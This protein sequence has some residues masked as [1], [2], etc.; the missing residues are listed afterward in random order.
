[1]TKK[2]SRP[3]RGRDRLLRHAATVF[4]TK[5]FHATGIDHLIKEAGVA[6][7][8]LYNNFPSKDDL[9]EAVLVAASGRVMQW[10]DRELGARPGGPGEKLL[11]LFDIFEGWYREPDFRG[12]LFARAAC[13]YPDRDHPAHMA[14]AQH[15]RHL[16]DWIE[17]LASDAGA[18]DAV[19]LAQQ[20][21]LLLQGA[22]T[23]AE[24]SGAFIAA[25]RARV[26]AER[27]IGAG[28]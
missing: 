13:E 28:T 26:V 14:A 11:S 1:M 20:I 8:T 23:V 10:L 19:A 25:R 27:L 12:C 9:A 15:Q 5:G 21:L 18:R 16:L 17:D 2:Q 3:R 22:T 6:K 4:A 7:M 24:I